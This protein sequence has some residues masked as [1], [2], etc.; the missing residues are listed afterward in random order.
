MSLRVT[1]REQTLALTIDPDAFKAFA[2]LNFKTFWGLG[3]IIFRTLKDE[4]GER[5]DEKITS[6]STSQ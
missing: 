3:R 1:E 5:K 6:K 4:K 2:R